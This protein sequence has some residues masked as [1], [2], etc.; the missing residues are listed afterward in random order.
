MRTTIADAA[1][2]DGPS[3]A[4]AAVGLALDSGGGTAAAPF[5]K[6]QTNGGE[7]LANVAGTWELRWR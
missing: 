6:A 1:A 4:A 5:A 3:G 2:R 7:G